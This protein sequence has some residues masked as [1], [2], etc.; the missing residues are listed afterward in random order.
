MS[1]NIGEPACLRIFCATAV[2]ERTSD[3][4]AA[5]LAHLPGGRRTGEGR[6]LL[7]HRVEGASDSVLVVRDHQRPAHRADVRVIAVDLAGPEDGYPCR[8]FEDVFEPVRRA[9]EVDPATVHITIHAGEAAGPESVW[10]AIELLGAER[11]GHGIHS[12]DDPELV[13]Y[14]AEHRICLEMCPTS[15][16]LTGAVDRLEDHPLRR[17]LEEGVAATI[18][19]DDPTIFGVS[20]VDEVRL[21]RRVIG[22]SAAQVA[23]T[24]EIAAAWTFVPNGAV[25]GSSGADS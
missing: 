4:H 6:H 12:F 7:G 11:I 3:Q 23:E 2:P 21:A 25:S 15:N 9:R 17:A 5:A 8:L 1:L 14:L 16:W 10:E 24:F 22:L 19:T 13:R 20:L 18:N